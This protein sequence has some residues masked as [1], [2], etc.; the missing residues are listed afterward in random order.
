MTNNLEA[1]YS[2]RNGRYGMS[3]DDLANQLH[4]YRKVVDENGEVRLALW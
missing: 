4:V 3:V 1:I 2:E